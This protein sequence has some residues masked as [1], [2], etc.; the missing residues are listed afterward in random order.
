[1]L[2]SYQLSRVPRSQGLLSGG[3]SVHLLSPPPMS[4]V[5]EGVM[6]ENE[7]LSLRK[8]FI[9]GVINSRRTCDIHLFLCPGIT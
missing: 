3:Q 4:D 7:L 1:M 6:L 5:E 2:K 9:A 8:R